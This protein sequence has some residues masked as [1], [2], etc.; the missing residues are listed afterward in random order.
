M[1]I[2][3]T[4]LSGLTIPP[5]YQ[6]ETHIVESLA[7]CRGDVEKQLYKMH[8]A[9]PEEK[10]WKCGKVHSEHLTVYKEEMTNHAH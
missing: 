4:D 9:H 8:L 1:R 10:Y 5:D 3:F 7:E 6:E 2:K